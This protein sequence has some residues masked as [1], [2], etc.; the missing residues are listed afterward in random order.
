MSSH[1]A[2]LAI[3]STCA[4]YAVCSVAVKQLCD[5]MKWQILSRAFYGCK[6]IF[7]NNDIVYGAVIV[8]QSHCL[9]DVPGALP[10][11]NL[12]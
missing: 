4:V 6:C 2:D 11:R 9:S 7:I 5:T 3:T 8:G 10:E 12:R 1:A